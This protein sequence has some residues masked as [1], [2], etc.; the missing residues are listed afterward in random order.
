M[1]YNENYYMDED[2]K[3]MDETKNPTELDVLKQ[4]VNAIKNQY[5]RDK[6]ETQNQRKRMH[7]EIETARKFALQDFI[8]RLLPAK[9][10]IE[11]G[12]D[13]SNKEDGIDEVVLFEGMTSTL[14]ICN[15]AFKS[16]GVEEI[17][18]KGQQF[19]PELHE[20]IALRKTE[21]KKPNM[22]LSVYLKGYLL[23]GRLIR[24]ARVEV[25]TAI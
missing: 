12:L 25:S 17:D 19:N 11:K 20:A 2:E 8:T 13:L 6:A 24:P 7:R 16:A 4:E 23:N 22:V 5:L 10:S 1:D 3:R 18:P 15:D 9:D 14:R 21:G